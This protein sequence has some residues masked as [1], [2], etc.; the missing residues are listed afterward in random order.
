MLNKSSLTGS[1]LC[2]K[3]QLEI[4][5]LDRDVV[6]CHCNQ[7]RKQSGH[8]VA[9]TRVKNVHLVIHGEEHLT[10]Y[11]ASVEAERGFC[12]HCGSL[13]MWKALDTATTSI[14]AG[15]LNGPTGLCIDRHI[16]TADKGDYYE[17]GEDVP[18][19]EQSDHAKRKSD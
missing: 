9:A 16:F 17:L 14:M 10:W 3:V 7:C 6:A 4:E 18:A 12:R 2:G 8:F 11:K 15:C 1:C 19:F 5:Q 13:L